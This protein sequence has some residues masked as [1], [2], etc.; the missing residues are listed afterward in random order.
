M[1]A[2]FD[3]S[4]NLDLYFR[5]G[6]NGSKTLNFFDVDGGEYDLTGITFEFRA[7][8]E[9]TVTV[10]QNTITLDF[11]YDQEI[12]RDRFFWQLVNTITVKTWLCGTAFFTSD[13]SD[14]VSD[15]E[16]ITINLEGE[17]INITINESGQALLTDWDM[18]TNL[19]P[20]NS[21]KG[22]DYYGII[23]TSSTLVDRNGNP[24]PSGVIAKALVNNASTSDPNDWAFTYT[25]I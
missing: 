24:L 20:A 2:T 21:R 18:D 15:S 9:V 5:K 17:V 10:F 12:K 7:P 19:F 11:A 13:L 1:K 6:R 8:F 16:N 4:V 23:T 25:I 3:P 14:A 22:Q